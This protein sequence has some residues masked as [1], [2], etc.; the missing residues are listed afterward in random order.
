[1][2]LQNYLFI[3]IF[4]FLPDNQHVQ[5]PETFC[6][7][8]IHVYQE[9][10]V[11]N[12]AW[13]EM[14]L[15]IRSEIRLKGNILFLSI[16]HRTYDLNPASHSTR[17]FSIFIDTFLILWR[18]SNFLKV[19]TSLC[20][21]L[22]LKADWLLSWSLLKIKLYELYC[23]SNIILYGLNV[24]ENIMK[25]D[26]LEFYSRSYQPKIW[27]L[28]FSARWSKNQPLALYLPFETASNL[29]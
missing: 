24:I 15:S 18:S 23:I 26:G 10:C 17:S 8:I 1:M 3:I 5:H 20:N 11:N 4:Q 6:L 27:K 21:V 2:Q 12:R 14:I 13:S 29:S 9:K 7:P 25:N 22:W 16:F 19:W 28:S